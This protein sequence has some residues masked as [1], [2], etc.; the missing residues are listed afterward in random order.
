MPSTS[1]ERLFH[2][3]TR[4]IR[5]CCKYIYIYVYI[6]VNVYAVGSIIGPHFAFHWVHNWSTWLGQ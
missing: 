5:I 2:G 1:P 3:I 4:E 6:R